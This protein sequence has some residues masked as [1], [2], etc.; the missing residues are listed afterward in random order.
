MKINH[1]INQLKVLKVSQNSLWRSRSNHLSKTILNK[2]KKCTEKKV[3]CSS[4]VGD[5]KYF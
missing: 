4:E 1:P 3:R 5:S 2:N